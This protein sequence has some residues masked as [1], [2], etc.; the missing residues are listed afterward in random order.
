M[1]SYA[2]PLL[3]WAGAITAFVAAFFSI[4]K[5]YKHFFPLHIKPTWKISYGHSESH[6][7]TAILTNRSSETQYLLR[8][9]ARDT[10]P[11]FAVV[12]RILNSPLSSFKTYNRL[13]FSILTYN[14]M[15]PS[16]IKI[17]PLENITL[18]H[19]IIKHPLLA[20]STLTMIIEMELSNGKVFRS[21]RFN[22]PDNLIWKSDIRKELKNN[23]MKKET[24]EVPRQ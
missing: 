24:N 12:K 11:F 6:E 21:S 16:P 20:A 23:K 18:T 7:I 1:N 3:Q 8:C 4:H 22:I 15:G 5:L 13:R 17:E 9:Q 14:L 10:Y 19:R 2:I